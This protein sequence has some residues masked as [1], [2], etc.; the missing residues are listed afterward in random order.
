MISAADFAELLDRLR[1]AGL[2]VG[3]AESLRADYLLGQLHES[4]QVDWLRETLRAVLV[5]SSTQAEIF[6]EAFSDWAV[7]LLDRELPPDSVLLAPRTDET[8]QPQTPTILPPRPSLPSWLHRHRVT[9]IG[10]LLGLAVTGLLIRWLWP[11]PISDSL[12]AGLPQVLPDLGSAPIRAPQ[13]ASVWAPAISVA[14]QPLPSGIWR[15]SVA[16]LGGLLLGS[17]LFLGLRRRRY[18]PPALPAPTRPG[19]REIVPQAPPS[20]GGLKLRLLDVRSQEAMVWGIGRFVA[21]ERTRQLDV[22]ATVEA[23]AANAGMPRLCFVRARHQREVWLWVDESTAR[24]P[25]PQA[26]VLPQLHKELVV[27][28]RQGGLPVEEALYWGLPDRLSRLHESG[29][30]ESEFAPSEVAERQDA[31]LVVLLTDGRLLADAID[32]ER[33][34]EEAQTLLRQLAHF[35]QLAFCDVSRGEYGLAGR[36]AK[37][38]I[39]VLWPEQVAKFLGG[40]PVDPP[41]LQSEQLSG[42]ERLWAAA[43]LLW[44]YALDDEMMYWVHDRLGLQ[45]SGSSLAKVKK[46]GQP[47][48]ERLGFADSPERPA[49][50]GWLRQISV[51]EEGPLEG[52]R[53]RLGTTW[54]GQSLSLWRDRLKQEAARRKEHDGTEPWTGTPAEQQLQ[55]QAAL[56]ELW[57]QPVAAAKMLHGLGGGWLRSELSSHL[58]KLGP[59]ELAGHHELVILPWHEQRLPVLA[60]GILRELGFG[61]SRPRPEVKTARPG[62]LLAAWLGTIGLAVGGAVVLGLGLWQ[63][64]HP[65]GPPHVRQENAPKAAQVEVKKQSETEYLVTAK[66]GVAQTSANVAA[67]SDVLVSWEPEEREPDDGGTESPEDMGSDLASPPDLSAPRDLGSPPDMRAPAPLRWIC[68]YAEY[69]EPKSGMVFV[70]VCGGD[71]R[72]GSE[73]SDK[74]ADDDEKPAYPVHVDTFW[75]G[76]YEVSNQQYRKKEPGHKSTFDGDH[77]PVQNV[78]WEEARAYCRSIGADLPTEAEWE[79]SARGPS[80]RKYPWGKAEPQAGRATFGRRYDDGPET[81]TANPK[82]RGPFGTMN[83]AGN[84]WEWVTDCFD[85]DRYAKR[86]ALSERATPAIPVEN[87]VDDRRGCDK[88]V[89]RGGSFWEGPRV[90]RSS[91]RRGD[92]SSARGRLIG[93][94]C[95]RGSGR[96]R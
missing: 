23:T 4:A 82:G 57:D 22:P 1:V 13:I 34:R 71:F 49:L 36:L 83:L 52:L 31:A 59:L 90:L 56:I 33:Y 25:Q 78:R 96:Q 41:L 53:D 46:L 45:L 9:W 35:P 50:L 14:P 60:Q 92:E 37:L 26:T 19:P 86:K 66:N 21:E 29:Q 47:C 39:P 2:R 7:D 28:L 70:K 74:D 79:Y 38:D 5:K 8:P 87:P 48:G 30:V 73:T 89:V 88:R 20:P 77:L 72:M 51:M 81:V 95:V 10:L 18:L 64:R 91:N 65:H 42:D 11:Q 16:L 3:V 55:M 62:R 68:P 75:V 12:D 17:A 76:K 6:D 93:F 43:C 94:R 44:P 40:V 54:L 85:R 84:V 32:S 15:G 58:S 61:G 80:G 63:L 69:K 24:G 27:S 67:E